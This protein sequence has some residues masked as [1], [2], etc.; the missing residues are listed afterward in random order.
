M[1]CLAVGVTFFLLSLGSYLTAFIH[2]IVAGQYGVPVPSISVLDLGAVTGIS[3]MLIIPLFIL[4][5]WGLT[6]RKTKKNDTDTE[7]GAAE[8][9]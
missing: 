8:P 4:I 5:T 1:I 9:R 2:W 6:R 3:G 7:Q